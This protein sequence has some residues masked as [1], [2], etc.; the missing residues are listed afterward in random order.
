MAMTPEQ[1]RMA[2]SGYRG[3]P[4]IEAPQLAPLDPTLTMA[5]PIAPVVA[6]PPMAVPP[7][8]A[9]MAKVTRPSSYSAGIQQSLDAYRGATGEAMNVAQSVG[10]AKE[11]AAT[12]KA[13]IIDDRVAEI[14]ADK[15]P[16]R[17]AS[18]AS[19][20]KSEASF[21]KWQQLQDEVNNTK[22]QR[23]RR[24]EGKKTVDTI[25][26][27]FAGIGDA[28]SNMGNQQTHGLDEL[29]ATIQAGIQQ[30]VDDQR[31]A[32]NDKRASAESALTEYG[33]ARKM[34]GDDEQ[35]EQKAY[36]YATAKAQQR[37][38][39]AIDAHTAKAAAPQEKLAGELMSA[40]LKAEAAQ[41]ELGVWEHLKAGQM[42]AARPSSV[43]MITPDLAYRMQRDQQQDARDPVVMA[44]SPG[45]QLTGDLTVRD[46]KI[47]P[48]H[49]KNADKIQ[50]TIDAARSAIASIDQALDL[51]KNNQWGKVL[52][53][54]DAHS[55]LGN[56]QSDLDISMKTIQELGQL[57]GGDM[58]LMRNQTGDTTGFFGSNDV[59]LEQLKANLQRKVG[60]AV[61]ARGF[62]NPFQGA[63][64]EPAQAPMA[65]NRGAER[66][67]RAVQAKAPAPQAQAKPKADTVGGD[68]W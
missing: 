34:F 58:A 6:P 64:P 37:Y 48:V 18:T 2:I 12:E 53:G 67:K 46:G 25:A 27:V 28:M 40:K 1:L 49:A 56:L 59:K 23:D 62:D 26:S 60:S 10:D 7:I 33:I 36:E 21:D 51:R 42:A 8:V 35:A 29:Q 61:Y 39:T 31:M 55:T 13:G 22:I 9:P 3:A 15:G 38:A 16:D 17:T 11:A 45:A 65:D 24:T 30:D 44:Q 52:P 32:L 14:A 50:G 63:A 20:A 43:T 66:I 41:T 57:T 19:K 54:T 5:P 4:M 47:A 68:D